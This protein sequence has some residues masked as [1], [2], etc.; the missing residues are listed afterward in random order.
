MR[1]R[2]ILG[3]RLAIAFLL[4]SLLLPSFSLAQDDYDDPP[5]RVARLSFIRGSVSF[6][7]AGTEDWIDAALNRTLT[8]GDA[9]WTDQ[10][11]R[12]A[13]HI[14]SAS[15]ALSENSGFT[16]LNLTDNVA[17]MQLS[18]G[19]LRLRVKRL[20]DNEN[21]EVDTPNLAF[22]VLR[23]GIYKISVNG[24]G[25]TTV[26]E[27]HVGEGE[28]TGGGS[29]YTVHA[30]ELDTFSG[31][32]QLYADTDSIYDNGDEFEQWCEQR[33]H[34]ED[35]S[36]SI[37]YVSDDVIGYDDLDDNGGW[38]STPD[39]GYVWFP[40]TTIV[41]WAP[42]HYGH[43][44]YVAALRAHGR[45]WREIVAEMGISKGSAQRA[46]CGLPKNA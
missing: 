41:G 10:G 15:I 46:F 21:F 27:D 20:G 18:S 36:V 42:Y 26:I 1:K 25:N 37:R 12:A 31:T 35:N 2:G 4:A 8:T 22:S 32:D 13:L 34:H 5:S 16:F 40:H 6:Q 9:L 11:A 14:G 33:D 44:D 19:T 30:G 38:R 29:A 28:V 43:W 39:Y 45:S 23:P 17:Q 24:D 3:V 7:P